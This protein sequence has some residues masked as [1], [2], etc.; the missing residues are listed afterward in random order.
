MHRKAFRPPSAWVG[1]I[2]SWMSRGWLYR[3][4]PTVSTQLRPESLDKRG[5][6]VAGRE[7]VWSRAPSS[8]VE[9]VVTHARSPAD[10]L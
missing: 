8:R 7:S 4:S 1:C 9:D 6:S 2:T 5:H 3:A 10:D